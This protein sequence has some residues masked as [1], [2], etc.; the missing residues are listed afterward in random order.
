MIDNWL[1]K[2]ENILK[3]ID[4]IINNIIRGKKTFII[5]IKVAGL[6]SQVQFTIVITKNSAQ[7]KGNQARKI[8]SQSAHGIGW[9]PPVPS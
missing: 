5:F 6:I 2:Q 4:Q 8:G 7:I 3:S 1:N 9:V